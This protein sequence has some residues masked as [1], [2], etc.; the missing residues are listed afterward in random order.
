M[1]VGDKRR[2][3]DLITVTANHQTSSDSGGDRDDEPTTAN[4]TA[5]AEIT[6]RKTGDR[7]ASM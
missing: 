6:F 5:M 3:A 7:V 2:L 4:A 1:R